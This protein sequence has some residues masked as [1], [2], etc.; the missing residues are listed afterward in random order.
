MLAQDFDVVTQVQY[1]RG[2]N[3]NAKAGLTLRSGVA[4]DEPDVFLGLTVSHGGQFQ[5]RTV[6][7][8]PTLS[9]PRTNNTAAWYR[10]TR[11][12]GMVTGSWS[13]DGLAW[14]VLG[15]VALPDPVRVGLAVSSGDPALIG[16]ATFA[17]T[18]L[19]GAEVVSVAPLSN[20]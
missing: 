18:S 15:T 13:S 3:G 8:G 4:A 16:L 12:A 1:Q 9:L 17:H 19:V 5:H 6:A 11:V 10:L 14:H 20:N 2:T 7:G